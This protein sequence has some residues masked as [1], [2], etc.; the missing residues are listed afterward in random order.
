MTGRNLL[1]DPEAGFVLAIGRFT[2]RE[3]ADGDLV[4]PLSG[5]GRLVD[6]CELLT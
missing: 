2:I 3:D 6:I 5:K 4:D 1:F